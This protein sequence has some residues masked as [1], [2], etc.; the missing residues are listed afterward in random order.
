MAKATYHIASLSLH[1]IWLLFLS[2]PC[3]ALEPKITRSFLSILIFGDSTVDTGNNNFISTIFKAN[4][5]PYGTDFPGHVATRRFSDGKLIPDMVA[6]KLGIKELVPP[7]L[8][9][10]LWTTM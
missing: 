2:K 8:D 3:T 5:S 9:P 6:S 4:Y 1:M 7:F 10:K